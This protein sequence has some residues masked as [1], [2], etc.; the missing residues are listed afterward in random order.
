MSWSIIPGKRQTRMEHDARWAWRFRHEP[1]SVV[2]ADWYRQ[3]CLRI[4]M[5]K[6][7]RR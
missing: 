3:A 1:L 2:L 7:A 5:M 4:W 6:C